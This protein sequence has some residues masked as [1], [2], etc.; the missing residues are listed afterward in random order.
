VDKIRVRDKIVSKD[1]KNEQM[2]IEK[3]S[4]YINFHQNKNVFLRE[5]L[6][7]LRRTD[8]TDIADLISLI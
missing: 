7:L 1:L 4:G 8:A 5:I 2:K 3:K 6:S